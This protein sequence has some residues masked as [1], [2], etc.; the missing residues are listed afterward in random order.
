MGLVLQFV[1]YSEIEELG[2]ARR[3]N[4]L[5]DMAK[6][7][8]IVLLEGRLK[9][10]EEADLIAITMEEINNK[11]KGIELAVVNPQKKK[12]GTFLKGIKTAFIGTL[13]GDRQGFTIIGPATVVKQIRNDP[14]KIELLMQDTPAPK[15][16]KQKKIK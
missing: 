11:F 2:P 6:Q 12:E 16:R 4:K 7:N 9:K 10:E 8:K 14:G 5:L 1:P 15:S 13:L 3:V